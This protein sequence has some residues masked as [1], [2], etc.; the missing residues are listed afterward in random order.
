MIFTNTEY[1]LLLLMLLLLIFFILK[2]KEFKKLKKE[3]HILKQ[4]NEATKDSNIISTADL[5]GNITYVNDKFCEVSLY[6]Y[7]EVL[8]K[9]HS[10]VRGEEDGKIFQQLWETIK[11]KK[12]WYGVLKNRKKNG[13]FY[14]VNINIRPILD[15]KNEIIEYIAIRHE[16]TDL[17]LKTEELKRNLRLDFLT[18]IGNR[19]KLIEDVSKSVNPC[20]SI[21]DIV[22]F[23]DV[24]DFFGYKTGDNVLKIVARKIEKLLIDK[25]NYKVYRDHS[26]TFCIVAENEDRDKFIKN[27]DEISK[28]IAK[29]PIVIKSRELYVQLSY[30][31]SFE[32]KENLLETANIIKRYSHANKNIII[33]DKALELEK[34]YEK[35]IFWT[36]KIKKALDEDKIVPYFQ[37]IYNLKTNKIE[38]YEALVRLIDG[39]NV[40]SPYYFLDISKKSKQYLQLTKTMIQKTFDYFKDKDFEFSINLTFEDIK[41]EYISSFIIELLKEYEIGH[42]VVFEIVESEEIDNFR[43]INEFFVTIREYGCKIAID[44]FGSGYSNFEYLAKLNVDY[45]KIDGSLIKDILINKSSQNIVSMLVNFAKG[46]KVKTIAEFVSNKD[47]LNKVRELGIDYVQGYYI[48]EPIASI[49]GLND[50]ISLREFS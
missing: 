32:S 13:E 33:Y 12:V 11:N 20:I 19:Y 34:D 23:S 1:L 30:V 22:S 16:I 15:E 6:T 10:I 27:V 42:R 9:P 38:K 39:N 8:G 37:P 47:I 36:L 29:V 17:V 14:W 44:D 3:N 5:K 48:K 24:N 46:Q 31:F 7:E 50:I 49:D 4:Y 26:D 2:L 45:I 28:T 41:S 40:I 43:K 25:E 18:N 35:N 21:L